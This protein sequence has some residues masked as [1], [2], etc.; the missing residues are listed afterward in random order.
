[1][2]TP[3]PNL[4]EQFRGGKVRPV[5][6]ATKTRVSTLP[7]VPTLEESGFPNFETGS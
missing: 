5:A 7:D 3:V 6:V 4:I 2:I 1:M